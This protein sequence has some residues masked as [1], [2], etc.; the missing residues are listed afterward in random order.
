METRSKKES[1]KMEPGK[2]HS[3]FGIKMEIKDKRLFIKMEFSK[4]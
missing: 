4:A 2:I 1:I 3:Q